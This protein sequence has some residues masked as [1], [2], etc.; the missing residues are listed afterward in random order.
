MNDAE[1]DN[2]GQGFTPVTKRKSGMSKWIKIGVPVLVVLIA[3]GVVVGVLV[4]KHDKSS[5]SSTSSGGNGTSSGGGGSGASGSKGG[6]LGVFYTATDDYG[7][8]LYPTTVRVIN[9][10][11]FDQVS[12]LTSLLITLSPTII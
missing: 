3:V 4:S 9:M 12:I 5:T 1:Y 2:H 11:Y 7:L 10:Q 6:E 8:P